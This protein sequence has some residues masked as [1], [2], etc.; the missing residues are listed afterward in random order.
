MDPCRNQSRPGSLDR[1]NRR[2]LPSRRHLSIDVSR[3]E[4]AGGTLGGGTTCF[5][6]DSAMDDAHQRA[7][8]FTSKLIGG[9]VCKLV[10]HSFASR[11][12]SSRT[13]VRPQRGRPQRG[14]PPLRHRGGS[15]LI[16]CRVPWLQL[17]GEYRL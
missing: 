7:N 6:R 17:E 5:R 10:W 2:E 12:L 11:T 4:P 1:P 14:S 9:K 16:R 3:A 8:R 13:L 15:L